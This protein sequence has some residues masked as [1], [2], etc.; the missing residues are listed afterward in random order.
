M[1]WIFGDRVWVTR[2]EIYNCSEGERVMF[3]GF[4]FARWRV[5]TAGWMEHGSS[6][7][8]VL[9]LSC[10]AFWRFLIG[11]ARSSLVLGR[12]FVRLFRPT[13]IADW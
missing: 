11:V 4:F 10:S 6:S 2:R 9:C 8:G 7:C 12:R 13:V 5:G 1:G 3:R